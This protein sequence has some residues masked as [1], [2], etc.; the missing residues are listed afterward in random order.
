MYNSQLVVNPEGEF[1]KSYKK[2]FLYETDKPWCGEGPG[3][4]TM[5]LKLPRSGNEIK[6]GHGICMDINPYEFTAP[7][8]DFEFANFHKKE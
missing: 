1:V 3:F 6:V 2:A 5:M 7:Y 4:D 8:E